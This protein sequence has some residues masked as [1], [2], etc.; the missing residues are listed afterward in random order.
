MNPS[1]SASNGRLAVAGSSLRV[2][3]ELDEPPHFFQF[4]FLNPAEGIEVLHFAGDLAVKRSRIKMSDRPNAANPRD[5]VL[6]TFVCADAKCADQPN[7]RYHYPASH[8]FQAPVRVSGI[9]L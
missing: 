9:I 2:E 7:S 5:E 3:S 6:P 1:R 8:G 4:F